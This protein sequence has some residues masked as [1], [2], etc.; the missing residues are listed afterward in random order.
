MLCSGG[1]WG[2]AGVGSWPLPAKGGGAVTA[3]A[4]HSPPSHGPTPSKTAGGTW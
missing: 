3:R 1:S 4:S 2:Q